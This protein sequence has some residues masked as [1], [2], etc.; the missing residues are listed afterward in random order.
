MNEWFD[1]ARSRQLRFA[2]SFIACHSNLIPD[3][4]PPRVFWRIELADE[5][6]N[7]IRMELSKQLKRHCSRLRLFRISCLI[8]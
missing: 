2:V 1:E 8:C 5:I 6:R 3:F 7:G 4:N